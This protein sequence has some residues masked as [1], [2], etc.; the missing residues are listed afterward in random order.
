MNNYQKK[1]NRQ[2]FSSSE[3][4]REVVDHSTPERSEEFYTG[5]GR[6]G[7]PQNLGISSL[8]PLT[9][10]DP[11]RKY[12]RP[13]ILKEN[14]HR[15][16]QLRTAVRLEQR[17][18]SEEFSSETRIRSEEKNVTPN[19]SQFQ[20]FKKEEKRYKEAVRLKYRLLRL[21][22]E[23]KDPLLDCG[24][25]WQTLEDIKTGEK[26][27]VPLCCQKRDL[28][29]LCGITYW[30]GK[31]QEALSL[32][33]AVTEKYL[34]Y[35]SGLMGSLNLELTIP[36]SSSKSL[37]NMETSQR[38]RYLNKLIHKG[39]RTI[40]VFL[41]V[42]KGQIGGV[43]VLHFWKS[44]S[45]LEPHYHLHI[46]VSPWLKDGSLIAPLFRSKADLEFL[47]KLWCQA[48]NQVFGTDFKVV[49]VKYRY[50]KK[51][52]Q[53]NHRLRY[54]FRSWLQDLA[55]WKGDFETHKEELRRALDRA[56]E[57][58][59]MKKIRW[60]GYLAPQKRRELGIGYLYLSEDTLCPRCYN[61]LKTISL[62]DTLWLN[63]FN[64]KA[65]CS[66]G[67]AFPL[68]HIGRDKR[69]RVN[70]ETLK[71]VRLEGDVVVFKSFQTEELVELNR[72]QV[73]LFSSP[74]KKRR[75]TYG[76]KVFSGG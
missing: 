36:E 43:C 27:I 65:L 71:L 18:I 13:I 33:K 45:P 24:R 67:H 11:P 23:L 70:G 53:A 31:K 42:E 69:W 75:F 21:F 20:R 39:Y 7:T 34:T 32:F 68:D 8:P 48:V 16:F 59:G 41:Q 37:D 1:L 5:R 25:V 28:C 2:G 40:E 14:L 19:R 30:Q 60:F 64:G 26:K 57:M 66:C 50:A 56:E 3:G 4:I 38:G 49:D 61:V 10:E 51:E 63:D 47:R 17:P 55:K 35:S 15:H 74:R 76:Y 29:P 12:P 73:S 54:C 46:T 52:Q 44:K 6:E 58:Q 62:L 9:V 72:E 22:P